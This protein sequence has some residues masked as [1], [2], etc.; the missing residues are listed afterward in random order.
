MAHNGDG[1]THHALHCTPRDSVDA[2][3]AS[4]RQ[5]R[6]DLDFGPVAVVARLARIRAHIDAE[7]DGVFTAHGLTSPS[8]GVLVTLA[9]VDDG[10]GVSQRRL[11]DELGLT[12][13]TISVRMD[14]LVAQGLVDRRADPGSARNTLISLT[15][16]GRDLFERVA[17]AHLNNERRLLSGLSAEELELLAALLRKLLVEFEGS[18]PP[19]EAT[20]GLG[21]TL[22]PA[23][24]AVAL[25]EAVGLPAVAGLLVRGVAEAGPADAAGFRMG[26]VLVAAGRRELRSVAD[27]Y[28]AIDEAAEDGRLRLKFVRGTQPHR[29]TIRLGAAADSD[30]T[31]AATAGR[32]ASGEHRL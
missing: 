3:L 13:G 29:A 10:G 7:L 25:R 9:R 1:T 15:S 17:P 26:D 19:A 32:S 14:R 24:V 30:G 4:W 5:R 21:L 18:R 11:M 31:L 20:T 23:H 22:A 16:R 28:A 6:S 27:L 2:L 12:S 8:F